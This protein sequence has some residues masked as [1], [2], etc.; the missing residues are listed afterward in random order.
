[1][2]A[3]MS[4]TQ[5]ILTICYCC[6][7]RVFALSVFLI[8]GE[9]SVGRS[10]GFSFVCYRLFTWFFVDIRF[11]RVVRCAW[12]CHPILVC[13]LDPVAS[14]TTTATSN[15]HLNWYIWLAV[16]M[17]HAIK[18]RTAS[19]RERKRERKN[20]RQRAHTI[21]GFIFGPSIRFQF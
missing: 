4:P 17:G 9:H 7:S 8:H 5:F 15:Q 21:H 6:C 13:N 14:P 12:A 1:M 10:V 16:Y 2:N 19:E 11:G 18:Y 20:D 3:A